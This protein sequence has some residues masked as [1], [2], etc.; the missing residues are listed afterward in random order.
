MPIRALETVELIK[1]KKK[2][3]LICV[4]SGQHVSRV[5]SSVEYHRSGLGFSSVDNT[6]QFYFGQNPIQSALSRP[7]Q[8]TKYSGKKAN[9]PC[10]SSKS[11]KTKT[12]LL[13]H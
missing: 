1:K 13:V 7:W 11:W 5:L 6:Q 9:Y 2:S 4:C 3:P 10:G 12:Q 8:T